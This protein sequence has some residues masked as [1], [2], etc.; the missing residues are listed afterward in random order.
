MTGIGKLHYC[1]GISIEQ[2]E[3]QKCLWIHRKQYIQKILKKYGVTKATT[4]S[5]SADFNTKLKKDDGAS[6]KVDLITY[7]LPLLH[8]Q[9]LLR[10]W[11]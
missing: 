7:Q 11:E 8:V 2:D 5:S 3:D 4:T 9:I 1:L 10:Q 6:N